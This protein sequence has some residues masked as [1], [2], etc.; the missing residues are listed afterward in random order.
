MASK[1][2]ITEFMNKM[3]DTLFPVA[4]AAIKAGDELEPQILLLI[5]SQSGD[6]NVRPVPAGAV[7]FR[8]NDMKDKLPGF[9]RSI[10]DHLR[11]AEVPEEIRGDE[12]VG[13]VLISDVFRATETEVD[14]S[15]KIEDYVP[16]SQ[17][18]DRTEAVMFSCHMNKSTFMR[19]YPYTRGEEIVF[20]ETEFLE[21]AGDEGRF[22]QL[23]PD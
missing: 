1:E 17:R 11:S 4:E 23:F 18:P 15:K 12:L 5:E 6:I 14:R 13:V 22:S 8:S 16:P 3:I 2:V 19:V 21:H 9:I 7:F 10:R 20:G